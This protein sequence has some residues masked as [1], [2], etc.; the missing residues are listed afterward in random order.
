VRWQDRCYERD[1]RNQQ[2]DSRQ[3]KGIGGRNPEE[4]T[5]QQPAKQHG[6]G[7]RH[8]NPNPRKSQH[9]RQNQPRNT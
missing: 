6:A 2:N 3:R 9:I 5:P 7:N 8:N 1:G 4:L